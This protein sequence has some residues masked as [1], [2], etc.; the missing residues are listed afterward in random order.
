MHV[1]GQNQPALME[2]LRAVVSHD[3]T[4][5]TV[6]SCSSYGTWLYFCPAE[7][8]EFVPSQELFESYI[9]TFNSWELLSLLAVI[10]QRSRDGLRRS[11]TFPE[12]S[13]AKS[14][15]I[16]KRI[17]R[18]CV[19]FT[20][21]L[22]KDLYTPEALLHCLLCYCIDPEESRAVS[23]EWLD[24]ISSL[25]VDTHDCLRG[26]TPGMTWSIGQ[27]DILGSSAKW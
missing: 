5:L 10:L 27:E 2:T 24:V 17:F 15:A 11:Y 19:S 16:W 21:G 18:K 4:D 22:R 7:A 12:A 6:I 23:D 8:F 25:G 26:L 9:K 20:V 1:G 3:K 14:K 13:T